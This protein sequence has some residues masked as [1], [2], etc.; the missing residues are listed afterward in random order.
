MAASRDILVLFRQYQMSETEM[1][2]EVEQLNHLLFTA[3]RLDNFIRAHE[4]FD[5]NRYRIISNSKEIKKFIRT[6]KTD[7]AF[8]FFSNKN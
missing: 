1:K 3:E 8:I 4:L 6:K 7:A 5:L 2:R